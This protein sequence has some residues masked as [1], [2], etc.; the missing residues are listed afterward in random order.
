MP[1]IEPEMSK[2]VIAYGER[3]LLANL[4]RDGLIILCGILIS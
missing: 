1:A 3:R 2:D 4:H